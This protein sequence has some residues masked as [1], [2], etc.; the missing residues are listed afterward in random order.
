MK[1]LDRAKIFLKAGNGGDGCISFRREK[2]VE[3]GGPDGGDGG[4]GGDI[5]VMGT[6][7]LNTLIDY[8][9]QQHFRA[10]SGKNGSGSNRYGA[11]GDDLIITVPVGT[12]LQDESSERIIADILEEGQR[13]VIAKGGHGGRGNSKFKSSVNQAPRRAE[14]GT[15]GEEMWIWLQL[16]LI[17]DVGLVGLPNAGK[18]TFL[19]G[20]TKARPK[21]ADYPFTT[22]IP[23]LGVV[24]IDGAEFVLADIPGLIA[25]A[26]S[27]RGLGDKFL[28]HIE[29][30]R[31]LIHLLDITQ[32]DICHAYETIRNEIFL[33]NPQLETKPEII[34]FNK[35]DACDAAS[36][37]AIQ[38]QFETKYLKKTYAIS[39]V[40]ANPNVPMTKLLRKIVE[41]LR[42][43][44]DFSKRAEIC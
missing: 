14:K 16:K 13:V 38:Q 15:T 41:L 27:G 32:D 25:G 2:F 1:F 24:R 39:A 40:N 33:Y 23:Q 44:V 35:T 26:H 42:N 18:S 3:F 19:S 34:V 8:R 29:R 12:E 4:N 21:I 17:A 30:C 6:Q 22:I 43:D 7:H 36:A 11:A 20:T 31:V 10:K 5:I 28:A 37:K 9:Y